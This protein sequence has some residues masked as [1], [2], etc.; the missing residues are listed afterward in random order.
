MQPRFAVGVLV[1][2]VEGWVSSSGYVGFHFQMIPA[3]V[4][5]E[6]QEVAVFIGYLS[7]DADLAQ[8]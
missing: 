3:G 1:L 6:P 7:W 2:Q 8:W 4:V 5:A